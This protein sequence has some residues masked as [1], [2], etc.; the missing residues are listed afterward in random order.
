VN[1]TLEALAAIATAVIG[2]AIIAVL[3]SQRSNT[4]SV[5]QAAG[6]AFTNILN[7]AVA[8]ITQ[9]GNNPVTGQ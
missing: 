5:I 6:T 1:S 8:P 4:S 9:G 7:A 2:V 3:V